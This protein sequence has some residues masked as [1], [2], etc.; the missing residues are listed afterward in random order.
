MGL[1]KKRPVLRSTQ[2]TITKTG[3]K[4]TI[5][6]GPLAPVPNL[7]PIPLPKAP[8]PETPP[9]P[10]AAT[11]APKAIL[12]Q[13]LKPELKLKSDPELMQPE[14]M[15][16]SE[17]PKQIR[18]FRSLSSLKQKLI[19]GCYKNEKGCWIFKEDSWKSGT[20]MVSVEGK[21]M[22]P[23]KAA[24]LLFTD[25]PGGKRLGSPEK[26]TQTCKQYNCICPEHLVNTA[27]VRMTVQNHEI[28]EIERLADL[29]KNET[30][31]ADI[32]KSHPPKTIRRILKRKILNNR[33]SGGP[34]KSLYDQ[35]AAIYNKEA[36]QH[37]KHSPC[38]Q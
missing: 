5:Y 29:G 16:P 7:I 36:S 14:L 38:K 35:L 4:T 22:S 31:I 15:Q 26:I 18:G 32:I 2:I 1:L 20:P 9:A 24:Y 17:K 25:T 6:R 3:S 37:P 12:K 27:V 11:K 21:P 28:R 23:A 30:E 19:E 34:S 10:T 33:T 13:E 8:R